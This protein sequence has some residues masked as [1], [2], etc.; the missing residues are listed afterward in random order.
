MLPRKHSGFHIFSWISGES[1]WAH[2]CS[3]TH[4]WYSQQLL[5]SIILIFTTSLVPVS[6]SYWYCFPMSLIKPCPYHGV[7]YNL[8]SKLKERLFISSSWF[9]LI[10]PTWQ[11]LESWI[12]ISYS[13]CYPLRFISSLFNLL[14]KILNRT[15]L[16]LI[17][18]LNR[19]RV[20]TSS[21]SRSWGGM[22]H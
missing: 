12:L 11:D 16:V 14:I 2:H 18:L 17:K 10:L 8:S 19:I 7:L 3:S 6:I 5:H 1:L 20:T 15:G 9:W 21:W 22:P 4:Q 13:L